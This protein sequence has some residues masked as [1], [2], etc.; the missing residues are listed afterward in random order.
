MN[1][2]P[3]KRLVSHIRHCFISLLDGRTYFSK[4]DI[5]YWIALKN[6]SPRYWDYPVITPSVLSDSEELGITISDEIQK[7]SGLEKFVS[8]LQIV[9]K[10]LCD[11]L[12]KAKAEEE[13][14]QIEDYFRPELYLNSLVHD[15]PA[16]IKLIDGTKL[17]GISLYPLPRR[18]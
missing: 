15:L 8:F 3:A 12:R 16:A 9:E 5:N 11:I 7:L 14:V 17:P 10:P 1:L 13:V 18:T 4:R 6:G 2:K